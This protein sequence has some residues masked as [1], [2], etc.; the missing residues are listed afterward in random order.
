MESLSMLKDFRPSST[1]K[2][3]L[4]VTVDGPY[5]K[6][7]GPGSVK[8]RI[9]QKYIDGLKLQ[10]ANHTTYNVTILQQRSKVKL[11]KNIRNAL[12]FVRTKFMYV[13]QHDLP[14]LLPVNH[15]ALVRTVSQ[16]PDIVRLVR[17]GLHKTLSRN[18]DVPLNG[19]CEPL[20]H[21]S[22]GIDLT[23]AHT[24][25][26]NNH[27]TTKAYYEEMFS[28]VDGFEEANFMEVPMRVKAR[29][30]CSKWGKWLYGKQGHGPMIQHLDGKHFLPN[31]QPTNME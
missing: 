22:Y 2:I 25:S 11:I 6:D 14:F 1:T 13:L 4:I 27:F 3:P 31:M 18:R 15:S 28:T 7:R 26:D 30:D 23:K 29:E 17:F 24:W 20:L 16:H 10:F 21:S 9:L 8:Q 12:P 19:T 5:G